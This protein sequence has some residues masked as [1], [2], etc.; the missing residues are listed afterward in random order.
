MIPFAYFVFL[1]LLTAVYALFLMRIRYGIRALSSAPHS[2][3][4]EMDK[5]L[6]VSVVVPLRN[7]SEQIDGLVE[8]LLAQRYPPDRLE[9]LLVD[10]HSEDDTVYRIEHDFASQHRLRLLRLPDGL[11][12]KKA[13]VAHAVNNARGEVVVTTDADCRHNPDWLRTLLVPFARGAD[14]VA[15]PVVFSDRDTLFKRLQALE[16][17]GLMGVG[18]GFFGIG[19]PR[20][21][22]GANFAYRREL[23]F[24]AGAYSDN[25]TIHSGDDEFLLHAI[26]YRLGARFA[27]V[28]EPESI[29]RTRPEQRLTGFLRQ[30]IRWSSKGIRYDDRRFVAFLVL[31]FVYFLMLCSAPVVVMHSALALAPALLMFLVKA[32]LDLSV[33]FPVAALL[34]QPLR[35]ADI[36]IAEILH[37]YYLVFVSLLG[38]TGVLVWKDRRLM[39]R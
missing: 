1:T 21:C 9:L 32:V 37:P 18:A 20:L 4:D 13:A 11:E 12:G 39:N 3:A 8:S 24:D 6:F 7:E 22:N 35:L 17:L 10:D 34:R 28:T 36:V 33:L 30:R 14:V 29:V 5:A 15:G 2:D 31:L 38:M 26:V 16:F 19:H 23:F 25:E 27:F